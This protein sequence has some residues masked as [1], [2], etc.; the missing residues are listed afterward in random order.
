MLRLPSQCFRW[1]GQYPRF[2]FQCLKY[3]MGLTDAAGDYVTVSWG[4]GCGVAD[5]GAGGEERA[6]LGD[7]LGAHHG[8]RCAAPRRR[9]NAR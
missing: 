5:G 4:T 2:A 8:R 7:G 9:D 1:H 3:L 6:G